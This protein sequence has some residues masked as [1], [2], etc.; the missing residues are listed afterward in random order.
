MTTQFRAFARAVLGLDVATRTGMLAFFDALDGVPLD[1]ADASLC[2]ACTGRPYVHRPDGYRQAVLQVGRQAGKSEGAA[3]RLVYRAVTAVLAGRRN[4][5]F[6]GVAQDHR[7][8]MRALLGHVKRCAERPHV[9]PYVVR[10]TSDVVEFT[11]GNTILVLPCRPAASRGLEV[12]EVVLDELAHFLSTDGYPRDREVWRALLPTLGMT[13]GKLIA[14]SSPHQ[15][16]GLLYELHQTHY[17]NAASDL[18]FWKASSVT[19]NPR[20]S[21]SFVQHLRDVD[22][23]SAE[24]EIDAEF[25]Q[26]TTT[27]FDPGVLEAC[28]DPGV[29]QRPP[30]AGVDYAAFCD[31]ASGTGKDAFTAAIAHH[32]PPG[33]SVLDALLVVRPPFSPATAIELVCGLLREYR[34]TAVT[35]DRYAPGFVA[36]AFARQGLMYRPSDRDRSALYVEV[37]PRANA[38][39]V[40][41]LDHP[42]LLKELRGLERHRGATKDRVDHRRGAHDDVANSAC[43]ALVLVGHAPQPFQGHI[44][45]LGRA[46]R[47]GGALDQSRS[48]APVGGSPRSFTTANL[49]DF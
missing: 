14:L 5:V 41:L 29:T 35:G 25:L 30:M 17:G 23:E 19:M 45:R 6:V 18:L 24:A 13:G 9:A 44:L 48:R 28:V 15:A 34:C 20:L 46:H 7:A 8:G 47:H 26:R 27:L 43:G 4:R 42:Q 39:Q 2:E 32:E 12:D 31:A 10:V 21:A 49:R 38:G 37:L 36:E 40:R 11:G 3:A 22:P 16:S 33:V 1:A